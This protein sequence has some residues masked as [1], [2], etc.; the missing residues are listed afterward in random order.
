MLW[1]LS[2][3]VHRERLDKVIVDGSAVRAGDFAAIIAVEVQSLVRQ[4]QCFLTAIALRK[5]K[6]R[7]N[8]LENNILR[9]KYTQSV[10]VGQDFEVFFRLYFSRKYYYTCRNNAVKLPSL[11][12]RKGF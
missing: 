6:D 4:H 1:P 11:D 9:Y 2:G 3:V 10:A 8:N 12:F 5:H 7:K